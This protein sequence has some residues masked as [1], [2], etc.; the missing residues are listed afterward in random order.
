MRTASQHRNRNWVAAALLVAAPMGT[1]V[2]ATEVEA[3][4]SGQQSG[5]AL[6]TQTQFSASALDLSGSSGPGALRTE[7]RAMVEFGVIKLTGVSAFSGNAS[8][9]GGFYDRITI[10]APGI[11]TGTAGV[12]SYSVLVN[13]TLSISNTHSQAGWLLRTNFGNDTT[14]DIERSAVL[15]GVNTFGCVNNPSPGGLYGASVDFQFGVPMN[16]SVRLVGNAGTTANFPS[17][18]AS[19]ASFNL[20][21][22]AYWGGIGGVWLNGAPVAGWAAAAPSGVNWA[23]SFAPVPEPA[24]TLLL[25]AGLVAL[26][27]IKRAGSRTER[28][29]HGASRA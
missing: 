7:S 29:A 15:C 27:C 5:S 28:R 22:S 24:T 17:E 18:P 26:S 4:V 9:T 19:L 1:A 11:A 10:S 3:R 13:G 16:L 14:F 8:A 25:V 12:L 2:A 21:N 6:Y 23:P 20:G